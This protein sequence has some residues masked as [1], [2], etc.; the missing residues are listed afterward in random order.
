[1]VQNLDRL[2]P[3]IKSSISKISIEVSVDK[4]TIALPK[5]VLSK[6]VCVTVG[7]GPAA[8]ILVGSHII[9]LLV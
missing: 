8:S 2:E 5:S 9:R 3:M 4:G 6:A 7:S 1:M